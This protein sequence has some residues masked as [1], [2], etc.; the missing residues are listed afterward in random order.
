MK[1]QKT[2][3]QRQATKVLAGNKYTALYGGSRSGKTFEIVG[4]LLVRASKCK[5]RHAIIRRTFSAANGVF[6]NIL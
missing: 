2:L 1:F 5:S 4:A 6:H 3:K